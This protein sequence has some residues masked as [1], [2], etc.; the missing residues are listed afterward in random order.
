MTMTAASVL[1]PLQIVTS[2]ILPGTTIAEP[3]ASLGEVMWVS[4]AACAVDDERV[5]DHIVWSCVQA[6]TG[7]TIKP[8]IGDGYW[9]KKRPSNLFA[10]FD[11]YISTPVKGT[12]SFTYLM[13]PGFFTDVA[14]YGAK[15]ERALIEVYDSPEALA[16]DDDPLAELDEDL[17]E[18][19]LGL[20][21]LLF[22]PLGVRTK[23]QLDNVPL[24][25]TA[26]LKVTISS[27]PGAAVEMG[28]LIIGE[29]RSLV[30]SSPNGGT[31]FGAECEPKS[32][33]Y[34]KSYDDGTF[35]IKKRHSATDLNFSTVMDADQAEYVAATL[36]QI[37]D[38][39]VAIRA[40]N[41]PG[42]G[43]LNTVGLVSGVVRAK[44]AKE[45]TG[46]VRVKGVI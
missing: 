7:R 19:A 33:S 11:Q 28:S 8:T 40:T 25:P 14:I 42:Y 10:P 45:A 6:H 44:N 13:Q 36:Q 35:E 34:I 41:V 46:N 30:G 21:E 26:V 9:L 29:W 1:I 15:G 20:Y 2:M 12:G 32:Y 4:G 37:Q 27:A 17:W 39:P 22:S 31:E 3:D 5:S 24:S 18:Q 16:A 43:Y 23:V 38:E